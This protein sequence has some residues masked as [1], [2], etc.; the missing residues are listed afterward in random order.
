[1]FWVMICVVDRMN[2][3]S[4]HVTQWAGKHRSAEGQQCPTSHCLWGQYGPATW[5]EP[6]QFDPCHLRV[7]HGLLMPRWRRAPQ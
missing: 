1:M 2:Q 3:Q 7:S 5:M 6:L 4:L